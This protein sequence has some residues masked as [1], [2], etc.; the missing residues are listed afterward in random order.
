[1]MKRLI[2]KVSKIQDGFNKDNEYYEIFK[3]PTSSE[4]NEIKKLGNGVRGVIVDG[5]TYIWS[6]GTLHDNINS[7]AQTPID[8]SQFR[9][10]IQ[11]SESWIIDAH[12][13]Y[14]FREIEELIVQYEPILGTINDT[15]Q[16]TFFIC[17][18]LDGNSEILNLDDIKKKIN[19]SA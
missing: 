8:I 1:M 10:T 13:K 7:Y 4:I 2:R 18:A 15:S 6:G 12:R 14:T 11:P 5:E 16:N 19:Q 3:N 17:F 9:F